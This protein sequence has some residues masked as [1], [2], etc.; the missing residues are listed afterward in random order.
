MDQLHHNILDLGSMNKIPRD[1]ECHIKVLPCITKLSEEHIAALFKEHV[2][3]TRSIGKCQGPQ[4]SWLAKVQHHHMGIKNPL[5]DLK[6]SFGLGGLIILIPL[7]G[8]VWIMEIL[9][10]GKEF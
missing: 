7:G 3:Q 6:A 10:C 8:M 4:G 1:V 9:A 2:H 5:G